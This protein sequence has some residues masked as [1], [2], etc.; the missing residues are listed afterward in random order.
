VKSKAH[1]WT[2]QKSPNPAAR[3][4]GLPV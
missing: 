4:G 1:A 2:R 3:K